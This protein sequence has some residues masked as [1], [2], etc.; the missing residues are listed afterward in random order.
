MVKIKHIRI[1]NFRSIVRLDLDV[2]NMSIFVRLD[3]VGKSNVL[4]AINYKGFYNTVRA[5]EEYI[6]K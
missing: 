5:M 2:N 6:C 3:D 4:K 1:K